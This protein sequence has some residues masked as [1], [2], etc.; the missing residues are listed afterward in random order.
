MEG[1]DKGAASNGSA[2]PS[3]SLTNSDSNNSGDEV[4]GLDEISRFTVKGLFSKFSRTISDKMKPKLDAR[5][6]SVPFLKKKDK[7]SFVLGVFML[8]LIEYIFCVE[9]QSMGYT[10]LLLAVPLLVFRFFT[11][12]R[13]KQHFFM[14]DFCYYVQGWTLQAIMFRR[15]N[16]QF[17]KVFFALANGPLLLAIILWD[18]KL[19][20]HDVDKL[21]SLFIHICP[22]LV[23]FCLRWNPPTVIGASGQQEPLLNFADQEF[24]KDDFL[25]ALAF[26][27]LWQVLYLLNTQIINRDR[28][29]SDPNL[30]TSARWLG[31]FQ[32]HPIYRFLRSYTSTSADYL[33]VICQYIYTLA[34]LNLN[35]LVFSSQLA[36]KIFLLLSFLYAA[37]S[38]SVYYFD[39]FAERYT[40]KLEKEIQKIDQ[41]GNPKVGSWLPSLRSFVKFFVFMFCSIC[42][43]IYLQDLF[44]VDV[45]TAPSAAV[46]SADFCSVS[47]SSCQ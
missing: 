27:T 42:L 12:H 39:I 38:A 32:P 33:L 21:T 16:M 47:A 4:T 8:V 7:F 34:A 15:T 37:W 29:G 24:T 36:H 41:V 3:Q 9:P 40:K 5:L 2:S 26:Y 1:Q 10:Y 31:G 28:L 44:L 46:D 25:Y 20:F 14:L 22:A 19:L 30:I 18:N 23:S 45:R 11:F 35:F 6:R 17:F 43:V 13:S